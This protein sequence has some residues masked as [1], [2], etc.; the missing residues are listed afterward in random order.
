MLNCQARA[1]ALYVALEKKGLLK[2]A[3]KSKED[4]A[5][6]VYSDKKLFVEKKIDKIKGRERD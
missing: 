6:L 2:E 3:L 5:A 1:L 4:F